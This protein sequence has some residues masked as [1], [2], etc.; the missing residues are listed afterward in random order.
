MY[1]IDISF[2]N[3]RPEY[4]PDAYKGG[5]SPRPGGGGSPNYLPAILGAI[6]GLAL[7]AGVAGYW[8]YL[9]TAVVPELTVERDRLN[10][11]IA[12]GEKRLAQIAEI[13]KQVAAAEGEVKAL[14]GVF[15]RVR[16]WS[17]ILQDIA[18]RTPPKVRVGSISNSGEVDIAIQ[19]VA[20]TYNDVNDFVL[21][22]QRSPFL[23]PTAT[24]LNG[25]Q[26][27]GSSVTLQDA[28]KF[29]LEKE[30]SFSI[31]T[32]LNDK[33]ASELLPELSRLQ[34]RGLVTRIRAL[35]AKG[36]IK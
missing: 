20:A 18:N 16:S 1:S 30:A 26:L 7:P 6:F 3:D 31:T 27:Q 24:R 2:L 14:A 12:E 29:E 4:R 5:K 11:E 8:Y 32:K 33:P 23:D 17:A 28:D 25:S 22:L 10:Q 36:V 13:N 9:N 35:Q 19:G 21:L 15:D 34:A